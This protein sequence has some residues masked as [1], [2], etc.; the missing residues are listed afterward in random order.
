MVGHGK[1]KTSSCRIG[2]IF[3]GS[4]RKSVESMTHDGRTFFYDAFL[5]QNVLTMA[6]T[7]I[8]QFFFSIFHASSTGTIS[9]QNNMRI[10]YM[11]F[12][13]LFWE[14]EVEC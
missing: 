9:H 1:N 8:I 6:V 4:W 2:W 3:F 14:L 13:K 11:N 7:H 10:K 12:K 5:A